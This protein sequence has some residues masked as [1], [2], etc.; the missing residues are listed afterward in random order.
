MLLEPLSTPPGT[1]QHRA[2]EPTL[3]TACE[4]STALA[5]GVGLRAGAFVAS[6]RCA[7]VASNSTRMCWSCFSWEAIAQPAQPPPTTTMSRT[8]SMPLDASDGKCCALPAERIVEGQIAHL[9]AVSER[10]ARPGVRH[11]VG[12]LRTLSLPLFDGDM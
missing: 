5:I 4:Q 1:G 2:V 11:D 6:G 8:A 7:A 9:L 3:G 10:N 12:N